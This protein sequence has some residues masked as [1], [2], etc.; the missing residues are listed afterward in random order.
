MVLR[1][2]PVPHDAALL[3]EIATGFC[4]PS[5]AILH[6]WPLLPDRVRPVRNFP[7][8]RQSGCCSAWLTEATLELCFCEKITPFR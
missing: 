7:D 4:I 2:A 5:A 6:G 3:A 8:R 1:L